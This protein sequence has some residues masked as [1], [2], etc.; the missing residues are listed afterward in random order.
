MV[1]KILSVGIDVG[2]TT[3]QL[4]FSELLIENTASDFAVPSIK[5]VDKNI[6]YRSAIYFTPLINSMTIDVMRI[7]QIIENEYTKAG[8]N[9]NQIAT[10]AV[11]ITGETARK[12][13]SELVLESLSEFAGDFV[14]A[15]AG[16]E[17][18][19]ILAG[20][21]AGADI[22]SEKAHEIV[23]NLDIGGGTTNISV[24]KNGEIIDTCCLDVGGRLVKVDE[25][26]KQITYLSKKI[27]KLAELKKI[28]INQ[29]TILDAELAKE[30]VFLLSQA[31]GEVLGF[32]EKTELSTFLITDKDLKRDY[33]INQIMCSGGVAD[34]IYVENLKNDFVYGDI[35]VIL[36]REIKN[37]HWFNQVKVAQAN[38]TIRATVIGAGN[39]TTTIS[40]STILYSE[41]LFPLKNLPAINI[42][43][44]K[45]TLVSEK[46]VSQI[47]EKINWFNLSDEQQLVVLSLTGNRQFSF[48]DIEEL[49]E[50]ILLGMKELLQNNEPLIVVIEKDIGKIVGLM[51]QKLNQK[52]NPIICIDSVKINDGD[53]IDIGSPLSNGKVVP[54]VV[55][56]LALGY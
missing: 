3:T 6:V 10:G 7:K 4:I 49:A 28:P 25:N 8:I 55:K 5:I 19:S 56:T 36:G 35:G 41:D 54:V 22:V 18:E 33:E 21:G 37:S 13:N 52:K 11:I 30:L 1:E 20:R 24:F 40:G 23:A 38:E 42:K 16:P 31:L 53:Y 27:E 39:H 15:T 44:S 51:L 46:L 12:K 34:C 29:G 50:I 48:N 9:K 26:T 17:L 47:R 43:L 14:V 2:T 45:T 32:C